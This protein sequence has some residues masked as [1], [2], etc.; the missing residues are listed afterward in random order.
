[1]RFF[2]A[3]ILSAS[4]FAGWVAAHPT[5]S[6]VGLVSRQTEQTGNT[7]SNPTPIE[8]TLQTDPNAGQTAPGSQPE[9]STS[10]VSSNPQTTSISGQGEISQTNSTVGQNS[11]TSIDPNAD[12]PFDIIDTTAE[13]LCEVL[14]Q[15]YE[16]LEAEC[17]AP[18]C[19]CSLQFIKAQ[20]Y[21]GLCQA[22]TP[23]NA[24]T[25]QF[26]L[27]AEMAQCRREGFDL[28]FQLPLDPETQA[29]VDKVNAES[30]LLRRQQTAFLALQIVGGHIGLPIV[31]IFA[32]FS[33]KVRRDPTFLNFCITWIFS[34]IV[35]S[36][37]LYDGTRDNTIL[38]SLG[39]V[40]PNKCLAQAALTEGAQVMTAC[41]T[42]AL[43]IR[44]WL[45]LRAAIHGEFEGKKQS[46]YITVGLLIAPYIFFTAFGLATIFVGMQ[47]FEIHNTTL[48]RTIPTNFYCTVVEL[49]P[50]IRAVYGVTLGLLI[51]TTIF[52]V[53]IITILYKHWLA[54][55]HVQTNSA[56]SLSLLL[57]VILF[58]L[59]RIVVAV[60]YGS[61]LKGVPDVLSQGEGDS[62]AVTFSLPVWIDMLQAAIPLVGT[63][64]LGISNDMVSTITFWRRRQSRGISNIQS[65]NSSIEINVT[66]NPFDDTKAAD[67][68]QDPNLRRLKIEV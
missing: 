30:A 15:N 24:S 61:V 28:S 12:S 36:L 23:Q 25:V 49:D 17:K 6:F 56:V 47:Q 53:S 34:S 18:H 5:H 8:P 45:G 63:F 55:R 13:E 19:A 21:C 2:T 22:D 50:F 64:V 16:V 48:Q 51:I 52:D 46:I 44:L 20:G 65:I 1:M 32:V 57:R 4:V 54:F 11:T 66:G 9:P 60:A 62:I 58:S 39:E 7:L 27:D 37:L 43:I 59:Y 68:E 41:S 14:C 29:I 35:F 26:L 38:N 10:Q 40:P 67:Y 42:L 31:L 3:A 33:R